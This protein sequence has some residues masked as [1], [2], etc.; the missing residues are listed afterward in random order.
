MNRTYDQQ[1]VLAVLRNVGRLTAAELAKVLR[2]PRTRVRKTLYALE[3]QGATSHNPDRSW[4]A[5]K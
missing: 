3:Q 4:K 2:W 5:T 1:A